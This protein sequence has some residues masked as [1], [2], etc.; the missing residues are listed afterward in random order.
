MS[1]LKRR[2]ADK[3]SSGDEAARA[4]H[5]SRPCPIC[6]KPSL[7]DYRPFCSRRCADVDL[8]RWLS[9][10]YAVPGGDADEDEDGDQSRLA[11][12]ARRMPTEFDD[13]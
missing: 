10:R 12:A 2:G 3:Q 4:G 11:D 13:R 6:A 7:H 1:D 5:K 8:S 9:G